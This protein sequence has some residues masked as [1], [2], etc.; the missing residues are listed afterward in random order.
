M[1]TQIKFVTKEEAHKM[2][3]A[4]PDD[5]VFV[6]TYQEKK[7]I[8]D[9]GRRVKKNKG[10]RMVDKAKV[11]IL[12]EN[13]IS[14]LSLYGTFFKDFRDREYKMDGIVRSIMLPPQLE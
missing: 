9:N 7:G 11:L 3:D 5:K 12:S 14:T 2:I 4:I 8:S 6:L 10:K 1:E 13:K